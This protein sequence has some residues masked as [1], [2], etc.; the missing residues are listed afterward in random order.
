MRVLRRLKHRD[1]QLLDMVRWEHSLLPVDS[2]SPPIWVFLLDNLDNIS[3]TESQVICQLFNPISISS[4]PSPDPTHLPVKVIVPQSLSLHARRRRRG[5]R[6]HR[7][8][9][10]AIPR[11][12]RHR[13]RVRRRSSRRP[14]GERRRSRIPVR[15]RRRRVSV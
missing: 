9:Q 6:W 10:R 5:R 14:T 13:G 12:G 2:S 15:R 7:P 4:L 3:S 8:L 1:L 11:C